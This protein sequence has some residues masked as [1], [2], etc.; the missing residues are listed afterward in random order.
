MKTI[1]ATLLTHKAQPSTTLTDLLLIGPLADNTYRGLTT[2]DRNVEFAPSIALGSMTFYART[3][4]EMS[5]LQ[6]GNDLGVNNAEAQTLLPV[7]TFEIEGITQQQIDSGEL[8]GIRFVVLRVN[9]NDLTTGRSEVVAGG[10]LGEVRQKNGGLTIMELRSLIQLLKQLNIIQLT[11]LGCRARFGSQALDSAGDGVKEEFPCGFDTSTLW[12]SGTVESVG[13]D[14]FRQFI[15]STNLVDSGFDADYFAPGM[16][17]FLTGDN[18]GQM[19][20]VDAYDY[21]SGVVTLRFETVSPITAGD[22]FEIRQHCSKRWTG[23]N[24][25]DTFWAADK[26][27]HFRGEPWIPVGQASRLTVPGAGVPTSG[28]NSIGSSAAA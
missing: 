18:A 3:G 24:S 2:L 1:D 28:T 26:T 15:D 19:I 5:A 8:D 25:C 23:H 27:L 12:V 4:M 13:T 21:T 16:V 14:T 17:R 9:Y 10:T 20:E 22:T 11:S 6:S 7:A